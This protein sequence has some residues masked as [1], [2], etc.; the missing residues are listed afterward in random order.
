MANNTLSITDNRTGKG[1]EIPIDDQL[2]QLE[3]AITYH[4][5]PVD[6]EARLRLRVLAEARLADGPAQPVPG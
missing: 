6:R 2:I 5:L 3:T 4:F 1:Y